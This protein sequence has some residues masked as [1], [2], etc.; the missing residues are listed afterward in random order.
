MLHLALPAVEHV[1]FLAAESDAVSVLQLV[2]HLPEDVSDARVGS[3]IAL[4]RH[5]LI[6]FDGVAVLVCC[7]EHNG[8]SGSFLSVPSGDFA[9]ALSVLVDEPSGDFALDNLKFLIRVAQHV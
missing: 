5:D 6:A 1:P 9:S 8:H 4:S 3:V 7:V 2:P